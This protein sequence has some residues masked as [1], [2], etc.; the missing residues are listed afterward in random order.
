[1]QS[2]KQNGYTKQK[3]IIMIIEPTLRIPLVRTNFALY[4]QMSLLCNFT[5]DSIFLIW[6]C[7]ESVILVQLTLHMMDDHH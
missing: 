5:T 1:M 2:H 7:D 4:H 3:K 6:L